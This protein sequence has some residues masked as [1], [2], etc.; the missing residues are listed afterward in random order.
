MQ[1]EPVFVNLLGSPE[2]DS[3][4]GRPAQQPYL[5]YRPVG[6]HTGGIAS[7]ESITE[8][9]ERLQMRA[10]MSFLSELDFL[11]RLWGLGTEEE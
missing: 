6:L 5:T 2:I 3:R 11:K 7:S 4:P 10:Q 8:L 1:A 9:H